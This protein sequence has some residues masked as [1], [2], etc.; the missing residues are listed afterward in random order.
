MHEIICDCTPIPSERPLQ[1]Y[2]LLH[3]IPCILHFY[4]VWFTALY[5]WANRPKLTAPEKAHRCTPK[6]H[7]N[8]THIAQPLSGAQS[9]S[10][11]LNSSSFPWS[12]AAASAAVAWSPTLNMEMLWKQNLNIYI[13]WLWKRGYALLFIQPPCRMHFLCSG[14]GGEAE[15]GRKAVCAEWRKATFWKG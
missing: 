6:V 10:S 9:S 2:M 15:K 12:A 14:W 3:P 11:S 8:V 13:R 7:S 1:Q 4:S 5:L